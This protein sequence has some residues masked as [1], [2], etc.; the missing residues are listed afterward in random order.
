MIF[1]S[2]AAKCTYEVMILPDNSASCTKW[3]SIS[4]CLVSLWKTQFAA[5]CNA[6]WLSQNNFIGCGWETIKENNSPLRHLSS[7]VVIAINR[8][9]DSALDWETVALFLCFPRDRRWSY[10]YKITSEGPTSE[11][12]TCLISITISARAQVIIFGQ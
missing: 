11:G 8:Y 5:I 1:A 6:S 2:W 10:K 12:A 3:Q 9:S 4:M 7:H